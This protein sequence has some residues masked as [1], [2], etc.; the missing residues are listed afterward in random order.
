[1][2]KV[3][4]GNWADTSQ[5]VPSIYIHG[6]GTTNTF[7]ATSSERKCRVN[8]VFDFDQGIQEHG[9]TFLHVNIVGNEFRSVGSIIG[10]I[11]V[12]VE[13][14]HFGFFLISE[15]LI[16]FNY[17]VSFENIECISVVHISVG[18]ECANIVLDH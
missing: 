8:F 12:N 1:M 5:V 18:A 4:L 9:A 2:F 13:S 3:I 11:S 7:S 10:V 17:V 15:A 6:T 16:E 14:L